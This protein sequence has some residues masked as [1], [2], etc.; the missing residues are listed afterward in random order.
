MGGSWW[1][2]WCTDDD[3]DEEEDAGDAHATAWC[4]SALLATL[5]CTVIASLLCLSDSG[6]VYQYDAG[7]GNAV[8][9]SWRASTHFIA[10]C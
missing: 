2:W 7:V 5:V 10:W 6:C 3:E 1:W 8:Y 9:A 4:S